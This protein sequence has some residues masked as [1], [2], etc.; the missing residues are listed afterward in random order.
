MHMSLVHSGG[1]ILWPPP[2]YRGEVLLWYDTSINRNRR[3][4][5]DRTKKGHEEK[6]SLLVY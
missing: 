3:L 1:S 5:Y 6:V 4:R 2:V